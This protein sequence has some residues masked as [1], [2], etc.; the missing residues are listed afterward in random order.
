MIKHYNDVRYPLV[1]Q[2]I[3]AFCSDTLSAIYLDVIKDRLYVEMPESLERRSAQT[4]CW[5]ILDTLVRL[6]AP[7]MSFTAEQLSDHYQE[8]KTE[9]IHLQEFADL[10]SLKIELSQLV[11][12]LGG[13]DNFDSFF[14]AIFKVRDALLKAIEEKRA[15]GLIK[16]PLESNIEINMSDSLISTLGSEDNLEKMLKELLVVSKLNIV[17]N[18]LDSTELDGLTA[19]VSV[20]TGAK[21]PRCWHYHDGLTI[22]ARCEEV[23]KNR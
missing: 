2:S 15:L 19:K 22:C 9:S 17:N 11:E 13:K 21:C 23:L 5:Y 3:A 12:S 18:K 4:A 10:E 20:A 6:I 7:I 14:T 16:H 1:Y 8:N